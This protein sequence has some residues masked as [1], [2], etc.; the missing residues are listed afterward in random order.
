MRSQMVIVTK[1]KK[2]HVMHF[3]RSF[4]NTHIEDEC[5]CEKAPCGLVDRYDL[6]CAEHNP[7]SAKTM[8]QGHF[9]EQCPG[10]DQ[11]TLDSV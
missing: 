2:D 10:A 3:G 4:A 5:P 6:D 1:D 8:R 9:A 11:L 7:M